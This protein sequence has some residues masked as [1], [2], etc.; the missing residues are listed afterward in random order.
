KDR[1]TDKEYKIISDHAGDIDNYQQHHT[2]EIGQQTLT[3]HDFLKIDHKLYGLMMQQ[4]HSDEFIVA[5]HCPL[6]NQMTVTS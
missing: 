3:V 5:F 1:L 4:E 2:I 6:P